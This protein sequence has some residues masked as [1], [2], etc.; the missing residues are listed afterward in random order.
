MSSFTSELLVT[1]LRNGRDWQLRKSFSYHVGSRY[2]RHIIKVPRGFE[3]DFA[4]TDV[5]QWLAVASTI[6]YAC[7][8]WMLPQWCVYIYLAIILLAL[9]ITPYGRQSKPAVLHDYLYQT[10]PV[11]RHMAD[12]IFYE[13]MEVTKTNPT[14]ARLM[15]Y[16]VRIGGWIS[17]H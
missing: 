15:Y 2:S 6:L 17:W 9:L 4:S 3:T 1:P 10:H 5:L 7:L 11:S 8:S 14:L 16:G 13:G 12:L